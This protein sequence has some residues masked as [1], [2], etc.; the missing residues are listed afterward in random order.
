M[1]KSCGGREQS[2][3]K[4]INFVLF[5]PMKYFVHHDKNLAN[6]QGELSL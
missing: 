6:K 5:K 1:T 3:Q 2:N 4:Q